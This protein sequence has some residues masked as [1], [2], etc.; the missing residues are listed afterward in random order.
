MEKG[1]GNSR[2]L[3]SGSWPLVNGAARSRLGHVDYLSP[4]SYFMEELLGGLILGPSEEAR[5]AQD[6]SYC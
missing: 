2:L 5:A 3:V 6:A 1:R 4:T